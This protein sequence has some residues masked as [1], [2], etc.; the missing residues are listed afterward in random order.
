MIIIMGVAG[1]GKSM[2]GRLLADQAGLPW[3][4]T[5]EFL[6]MLI[7]GERRKEMLEGKLLEDQEII[8]MVQKIFALID[9]KQ[10]FVLDGF[11]RTPGQADWLLSQ[12][13]HGQLTVSAVIHLE[14]SEEAVRERLLSRGRQDDHSDAIHERFTEYYET[15][16]PILA[17]FKEAGIIVHSIN[18][19]QPV[20]AV[21]AA[22]LQAVNQ[23]KTGA[24][25][26]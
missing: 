23:G 1:S 15:I 17:Q 24:N 2:Q 5:G 12:A 22:I 9:V 19:E 16:L 4:S 26:S 6:R 11:P 20:E 7:A 18:G 21:H 8:A 14:A 25:Q 10:E 13:S 3:I